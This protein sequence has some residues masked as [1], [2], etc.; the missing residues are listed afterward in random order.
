MKILHVSNVN[1]I[2]LLTSPFSSGSIHSQLPDLENAYFASLLKS[3]QSYRYNYRMI[4]LLPM[5]F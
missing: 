3:R 2:I 5:A 4:T 1:V